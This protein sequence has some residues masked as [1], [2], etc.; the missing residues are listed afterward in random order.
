M[1]FDH[2]WLLTL[3][4]L[5]MFILVMICLFMIFIV[6]SRYI[7]KRYE[8]ETDLGQ[9]KY[10]KH[11]IYL[12]FLPSIFKPVFYS[13]HLFAAMIL[14]DRIM[15]KHPAFIDAPSREEILSYFSR[16]ERIL[17]IISSASCLLFF[18][19]ILVHLSL[20]LYWKL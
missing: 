1:S 7:V 15:K 20:R 19:F 10:F 8:E 16:K 14:N 5:V 12:N 13:A 4:E 2:D 9:N 18:I 17:T 6:Q 11:G 3:I